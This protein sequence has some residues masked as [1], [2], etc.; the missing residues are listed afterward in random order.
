M[1]NHHT[2]LRFKTLKIDPFSLIIIVDNTGMI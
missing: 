2:D 1:G